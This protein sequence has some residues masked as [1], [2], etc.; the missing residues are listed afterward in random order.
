MAREMTA[1]SSDLEIRIQPIKG[2]YELQVANTFQG[3]GETYLVY[4]QKAKRSPSQARLNY[5]EKPQ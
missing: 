2:G 1:E 4:Y 5:Q 3:N